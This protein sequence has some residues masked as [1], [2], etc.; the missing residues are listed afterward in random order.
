MQEDLQSYRREVV[1]EQHDTYGF[2]RVWGM[3]PIVYET[4]KLPSSL[5]E[6]E[7]MLSD[8]YF[9]IGD[10][11]AQIETAILAWK[12]G[13]LKGLTEDT[14]AERLDWRRSAI[15]KRRMLRQQMCIL[16]K[17]K[18]VNSPDKKVKIEQLDKSINMILDE[19]E[20]LKQGQITSNT[21]INNWESSL[22]VER[23]HRYKLDEDQNYF[24]SFVLRSIWLLASKF[25][26][27]ELEQT[28]NFVPSTVLKN[29]TWGRLLNPIREKRKEEE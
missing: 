10:I 5:E 19:L 29:P 17:W 20:T 3:P 28:L 21:R 13:E 2:P 4:T 7:E 14:S 23:A 24:R 8:L 26:L 11:T 25:K 22:K 27:R 15:H 1:E 12:S 18:V 16:T 6:C 9:V